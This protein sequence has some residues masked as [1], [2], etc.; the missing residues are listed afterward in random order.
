MNIAVIIPS[1][2]TCN[3]ILKVI[4]SIGSEVCKIYVV[5]DACPENSGD[6][7]EEQC[8]DPRVSVIRH[9]KNQ[10]VGGAV[11]TGYKAAIADN[12]DILVKIDGDGQMDPSLINNFIEPI[13]SGQAD[14]TKGNRFF[15]LEKIHS[16]PKMRLF[17][18][19][20]LSLMCKLSSGYWNTFDPTNGYTPSYSRALT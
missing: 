15:D 10:G 20:A 8:N 2:K 18:N 13:I 12:M 4:Q 11:I 5:D 19:A 16:M 7:V 9:T 3:H 14:Y 1:Y 17:G 6:L